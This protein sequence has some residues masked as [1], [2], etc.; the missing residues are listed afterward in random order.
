MTVRWGILGTGGIARKMVAAVRA[1][2][3]EVVA[4]ASG[5]AA[6]ARAFADEQNVASAYGRHHD[7]LARPEDVDVVYVATTN[8]RHHLDAMA[9]VEAGV[10]VLVEKPFALDLERAEAVVAAARTAGTFVMEAMWMRFQPGFVEAERRVAAGQVGE[11]L[12]VQADFGIAAL[13]DTDRRWFSRELGGG[14]LLDVGIYPLTFVTSVLGTPTRAAALG[15]LADTGVDA[16]VSVAMR[17]GQERLSS[18]SCSFVADTGVEATVAGREGSLRLH[19]PFHAGGRLSLRRGSTVVEEHALEGPENGFEHEV[20]EVVH[21]IEGGRSQSERMPL[22]LTLTTMRWLD[23]LR[24]QVG[25][26]YPHEDGSG[27]V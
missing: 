1:R 25:V 12:L 13:P 23:E 11:P 27:T 14:A 18:W 20:D 5:D 9:C 26:V 10:P 2:G 17:H 22:A 24:R 8:D 19:G 21:C 7:L 4:V 15:T 3:G 16:T 6:R